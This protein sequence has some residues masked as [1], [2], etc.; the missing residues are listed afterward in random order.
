MPGSLDLDFIHR[1]PC[2]GQNGPLLGWNASAPTDDRFKNV[3]GSRVAGRL[4][5]GVFPEVEVR[6]GTDLRRVPA[7]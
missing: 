1:S 4:R 2:C 6:V 5:S 3:T 7:V